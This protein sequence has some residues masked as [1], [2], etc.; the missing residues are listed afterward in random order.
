MFFLWNLF[1]K[2]LTNLGLVGRKV[3]LPAVLAEVGTF[4]GH[5]LLSF[6]LFLFRLRFPQARLL[7]LGLDNAG[8]TTLLRVLR[9]IRAH[10]CIGIPIYACTEHV[11]L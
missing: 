8:K 7:L 6:S 3:R 5:P 1:W 2:T 4:L 11:H 10:T 9:Y